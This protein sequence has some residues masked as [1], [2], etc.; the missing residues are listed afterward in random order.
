[1]K[2]LK[3]SRDVCRIE[4]KRRFYWSKPQFTVMEYVGVPA[5]LCAFVFS[6]QISPLFPSWMK[7][8][9]RLLKNTEDL[10]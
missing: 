7:A 10:N 9:R 1:M 3:P 5:A 8:A 2:R 4:Q 6:E